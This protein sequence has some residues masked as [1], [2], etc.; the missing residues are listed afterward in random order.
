MIND[1]KIKVVIFDAD[2]VII[3]PSPIFSERFSLEYGVEKEEMLEFFEGEFLDCL[4]G[5]KD[6]KKI[7]PKY[8]KRW[9][10]KRS[11]EELLV[12]WFEIERDLDQDLVGYIHWL[13]DQGVMVFVGTNNEKH[14][15]DYMRRDLGFGKIFHAVYGSGDIGYMKPDHRFFEHILKDNKLVGSEVLFW[16]DRVGNVDAARTF[17]MRAEVYTSFKD[18]EAVMN[19]YIYE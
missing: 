16:D 19:K 5:K 1:E 11:V 18:F 15:T 10:W 2:G 6:L 17:G 8:M 12:Y 13:K 14:R 7:L 9:G 4:V 3:H